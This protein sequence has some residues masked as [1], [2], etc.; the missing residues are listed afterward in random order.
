MSTLLQ[1]LCN[2]QFQLNFLF[3]L[4]CCVLRFVGVFLLFCHS[5]NDDTQHT[6]RWR[7][8]NGKIGMR[9]WLS[10][11]NVSMVVD[12]FAWCEFWWA[13]TW[14]RIYSTPIKIN[15]KIFKWEALDGCCLCHLTA[16]VLHRCDDKQFLA[17]TKRRKKYIGAT[18]DQRR[19]D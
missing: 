8:A 15:W 13:V 19:N 18:F 11:G 1:F 6:E 10:N 4:F 16:A 14:Q 3:S 9:K 5:H 2:T 12:L 17:S 7:W